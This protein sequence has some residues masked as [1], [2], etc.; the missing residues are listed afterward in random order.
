MARGARAAM[1]EPAW[2]ETAAQRA[3]DR[4]MRSRQPASVL[5]LYLSHLHTGPKPHHR[6]VAHC[7]FDDA[8]QQAG[9]QV[10]TCANGD[11]VLIA[12]AEPIAHLGTVLTS[13]FRAEAAAD[14]KL[15]GAWSLP[16]EEKLVRAEFACPPGAANPAD[17]PPVPLGA[18]AAIGASLAAAPHG[19]LV[20]RQT[21]VRID[22][23][24]VTELFHELSVS[25]PA[26]E[27]RIGMRVP[28]GADPYL[29]RYMS[30]QLDQE[31]LATLAAADLS[32]L[33]ALNVNLPLAGVA[34]PGFAALLASTKRI[35]L[36]LGVE[37]PFVEAVADTQLYKQV[38]DRLQAA[39]CRVV[40]DGLAHHTLL[41]SD[42][43]FLQPDLVKLE[44][45]AL[46]TSQPARD[47]RRLREALGAIGFDRIVLCRAETEAALVWG[48]SEAISRFQGRHVDAMLAADRIRACHYAAGC[49]LRQC[50][51]RA[52]ATDQAGQVGCRDTALLG[53]I[54]HRP[55]RRRS[56]E[57]V[58]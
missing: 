19:E 37:L 11:L 51:D 27:A 23:G 41:Q 30:G 40:L 5:R 32:P 1:S 13:L 44:W 9:G 29:F 26:I 33:P 46:I 45:S 8:V 18:L 58:A 57:A 31:M 22:G 28:S 34:S 53:G 15:L 16:E 17:E 56:R 50:I 25:L 2:L 10:F 14:Q 21:A 12:G 48:L 54:V 55:A 43:A 24:R 38:R 20:R 49:S 35:G 39:G 7:L 4:V 3:L 6:L 42:P 47:A 52:A 36:R